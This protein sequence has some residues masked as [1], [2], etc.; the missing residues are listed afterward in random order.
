MTPFFR[1]RI[2]LTGPP[3]T[4]RSRLTG[5]PSQNDT[6]LAPWIDGVVTA[7]VLAVVLHCSRSARARSA[8]CSCN[9]LTSA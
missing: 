9:E 8:Y 1:D 7:A 3:T 4:G 2:V 5:L 6:A